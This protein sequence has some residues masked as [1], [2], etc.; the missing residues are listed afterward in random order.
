MLKNLTDDIEKYICAMFEDVEESWI[1]IRR[2][3]L[4]KVFGFVPSQIN[5][6]LRSRFTP[7]RGY[8]IE[9]QRGGHGFVKILKVSCAQPQEKLDHVST[10][11]GDYLSEPEAKRIIKAFHNRGLISMRERVLIDLSFRYVKALG[12]N[13][14]NLVQSDL[15]ALYA[16]V[17]KRMLK[18][19]M[20]TEN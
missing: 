17:L 5:Y 6:V 8:L 15:E 18:A 7:E 3:D 19:M 10:L 12:E 20:I 16:D 14:F 2:K 9:S 11:I 13:D 4:A 1:Q